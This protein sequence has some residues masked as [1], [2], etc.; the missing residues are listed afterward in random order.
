MTSNI[1]EK[2]KELRLNKKMTLKELSELTDLS[3]GFLSQ[4][5]RGLTALAITSL[6]KIAHAL[7]VDL[8]FF[9]PIK[10][11][12]SHI[13]V[14]SYERDLFQIENDTFL[15]YHLSNDLGTKNFLPRLIELLPSNDIEELTAYQHEG[16]EFI[17]VMEGILTVIVNGE[18]YDLYPGDS[19]HFDSSNVHNWANHTN[20]TVK[21][22]V[23][24]YP[25]G[26]KEKS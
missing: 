22:L 10:K 8:S 26:F 15:H 11:K 19:A 6:E 4:V 20:K 25:N 18:R 3:I 1:G 24:N 2:I 17:F 16:E 21:V 13:V 23:V 7:D 9:F 5:E 14:R 12:S